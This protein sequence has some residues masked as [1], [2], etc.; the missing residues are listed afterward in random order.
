MKHTKG[1]SLKLGFFQQNDSIRISKNQLDPKMIINNKSKRKKM[2]K[3]SIIFE[4]VRQLSPR[5]PTSRMHKEETGLRWRSLKNF[6][7]LFKNDSLWMSNKISLCLEVSRRETLVAKIFHFK[8]FMSS[9]CVQ[10]WN[11][12]RSVM[13]Q[14]VPRIVFCILRSA[15]AVP[16]QRSVKS[17]HCFIVCISKKSWKTKER[18]HFEFLTLFTCKQ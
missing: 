18:K 16:P 15:Q 9:S 12:T 1:N 3:Q 7:R 8:T 5:S 4:K 2:T 14:I 13:L 17:Q 11:A 6:K 10:T